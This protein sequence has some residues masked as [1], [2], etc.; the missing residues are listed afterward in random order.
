LKPGGKVIFEQRQDGKV[1]FH[2]GSLKAGEA[3]KARTAQVD[4]EAAGAIDTRLE[5]SGPTADY[6]GL[7]RHAAAQVSPYP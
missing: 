1:T 2:E 3:R 5:V 7:H 4:G 6:I